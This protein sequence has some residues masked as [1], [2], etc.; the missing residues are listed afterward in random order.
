MDMH[1]QRRKSS[2]LKSMTGKRQLPKF[3]DI[4][5]QQLQIQTKNQDQ[6]S[7]IDSYTQNQIVDSQ[8]KNMLTHLQKDRR[9]S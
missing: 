3:R 5:Q 7:L 8:A 2:K 6:V 9:E 4:L 1:N